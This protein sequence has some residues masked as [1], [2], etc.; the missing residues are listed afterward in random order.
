MDHYGVPALGAQ[1]QLGEEIIPPRSSIEGL[2]ADWYVTASGT[3]TEALVVPNDTLFAA[4]ELPRAL[5]DGMAPVLTLAHAR[6]FPAMIGSEIWGS[7]DQSVYRQLGSS[8]DFWTPLVLTEDMDDAWEVD[9]GPLGTVLGL[10]GLS[11][12]N[13]SDPAVEES[14]RAGRQILVLTDG[15]NT[16]ICYLRSAD[17]LVD[18]GLRLRGVIRARLGT[19]KRQWPT[20]TVGWIALSHAITKITDPLLQ[21]GKSLYL[22]AQPFT[23]TKALALGEVEPALVYVSGIS[24]KPATPGSLRTANHRNGWRENENLSLRWEFATPDKPL[25]GAGQQDFGT[26]HVYVPPEGRFLVK[27]IGSSSTVVLETEDPFLVYTYA[28]I[29]NKFPGEET[30]DVSVQH[31]DGVLASEPALLTVTKLS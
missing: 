14:W 4:F 23:T 22:R 18:N 1:V 5:T 31:V 9:Q 11:I 24:M 2:E 15:V 26:P 7:R 30:I 3:P 6:T 25:T 20:G 29:Q 19:A 17:L 13:L 27:L 12:E 21:P 16:E 28:Q 8:A 10:D